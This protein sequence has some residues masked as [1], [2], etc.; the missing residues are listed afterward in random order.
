MKKDKVKEVKLTE[1]NVQLTIPELAVL[2]NSLESTMTSLRE[3]LNNEEIDKQDMIA[4]AT[5]MRSITKKVVSALSF[6]LSD[7]GKTRH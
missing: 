6:Q 5:I 3:Q 4:V 1:V 7:G 2:K